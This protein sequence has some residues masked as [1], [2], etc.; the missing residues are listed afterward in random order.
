[1]SNPQSSIS[2]SSKPIESF[3]NRVHH[4]D[5]LEVMRAMPA[6]SV[7]LVVTSP[8]YNFRTTSG[9]TTNQFLRGGQAYFRDGFDG[10]SDDMPD[11]SYVVWQRECLSAMM[12]LLSP[13]GAIFYN[14][15]WRQQNNLLQDRAEIVD[16]FPVRQIIIWDR[17]N[18]VNFCRNFFVPSYQVVY[19]IANPKF[20]VSKRANSI[21]DVWRIPQTNGNP[22]PAPFPLALPMRCIESTD[23]QVI[24]DPF[25][26]SGTTAIAAMRAGRQWIGIEQSAEYCRMAE[27]RIALEARRP[28]LFDAVGL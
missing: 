9:P 27:E 21:R 22:H 28:S 13:C 18:G 15:Q 8:P 12:R 16:G 3:L 20:R 19:L 26:G 1:M 4:G 14:H 7:D 23:A 6:G 2:P 5:C 24:L 10:Y 25:L 17:G 11:G